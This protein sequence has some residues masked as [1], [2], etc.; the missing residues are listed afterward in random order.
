[1]TLAFPVH[2]KE[3]QVFSATEKKHKFQKSVLTEM[4]Y[5]ECKM[6]QSNRDYIA[7]V[8]VDKLT[9]L[10]SFLLCFASLRFPLTIRSFSI[11]ICN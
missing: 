5:N 3:H 10:V 11:D 6:R 9:T 7:V 4:N 2:P 1:M 8:E